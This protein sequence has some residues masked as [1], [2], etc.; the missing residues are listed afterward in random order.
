MKIFKGNH[1]H[2][3]YN[4]HVWL[5]V[6]QSTETKYV[7]SVILYVA[8]KTE[9]FTKMNYSAV[10]TYM[11]TVHLQKKKPF[12]LLQPRKQFP[13]DQNVIFWQKNVNVL[14]VYDKLIILNFKNNNKRERKTF[15]WKV[16][17]NWVVEINT[18]YAEEDKAKYFPRMSSEWCFWDFIK[19]NV[20][21]ES[22]FFSLLLKTLA[23]DDD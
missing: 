17:E 21:E 2:R 16:F 6:C 18:L 8:Y 22:V 13:I 3:Q 1:S 11:C 4:K 9:F 23:I 14:F 20:F 15:C 10:G 5:S 19:K 12:F 7:S